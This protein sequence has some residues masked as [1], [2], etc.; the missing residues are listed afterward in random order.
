MSLDLSHHHARRNR[1]VLINKLPHEPSAH[2]CF[3][4][5]CHATGKQFDD[6]IAFHHSRTSW[7]KP[8]RHDE[9]HSMNSKVGDDQW[10]TGDGSRWHAITA[11][12]GAR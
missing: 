1:I 12:R 11:A 7:H 2:W 4:I 9:R 3:K 8:E 6:T 10:H 5:D